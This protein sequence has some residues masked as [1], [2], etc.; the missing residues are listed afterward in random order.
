MRIFKTKII[1]AFIVL[2]S[3]SNINAQLTVDATTYTPTQLVQDILMGG[4]V[5]VSNVQFYGVMNYSGRY[6]LSYFTTAGTTTTQMGIS[7]GVFMTSGNVFEIPG[8]ANSG[9]ASRGYTSGT[10]GEVRNEA[11][12]E[13]LSGGTSS[14]NVAILE[15]DFVPTS[16]S[17]RFNYVFGSEEYDELYYNGIG[18]T[19]YQCSDYND[20]FGFLLSG[21]GISG[22]FSNSAENIALLA[23]G[24]NVCINSVNSGVVGSA[25]GAPNAS[26]C[27]AA[28]PDWINGTFSPEF[29]G[30]IAGVKFDGNTN[31]LTA[32]ANVTSGATYHIKLLVA[33]ISD[34]AYDSGVFLEQGSFISVDPSCTSPV[35][36]NPGSASACGSYTLPAQS[37]IGGTNLNDPRYFNN[38]QASGG[39]EITSLTL[40]SSQTVY[41]YDADGT[42]T[43]EESFTV[44]IHTPPTPAITGATSFC[45]GNSVTL[46]AGAGYSTYAWSNSTSNQSATVNSAG[47][48]VVTVTD[49]FGCTGT[50]S[51]IVT[52]NSNPTPVITGTLSFCDGS[53]TTINAGA[54]YSTYAWSNSTASQTTNITNGGTYTVTVTDSNG[55]SGTDS[56]TVT[57]FANP[58]A[59][60]TGALSFCSGGNTTL[61]A[62]AG[63]STYAWSNSTSS[64][65][66]T[67]NA[68]GSFTVTITDSNGC[69]DT[70]TV[71][72][73]ESASLT[74]VITGDLEFCAG[75]NTTLDA[76]SGYNDYDWSET[77]TNQTITVNAG[78]TFTVTVTDA[79]GCTGTT[80]ATVTENANPTPVI[81]GDLEFCEGEN[82]DLDAGTG[83]TD[84]L[85]TGGTSAQTLNVTTGGDYSVTVTDA[86]GC[87]GNA[88]VNI[89]VYTNPVADI[90]G[91]LSICSG[92]STTLD[93]GTGFTG[94]LWTGGS[95]SQTLNVTTGGTYQVTITGPGGCTATDAVTVTE[96]T[97]PVPDIIGT[98]EI[99]EGETTVLDAGSGY[100]E[101]NWT[102]GLTDQTVSTGTA[103]DFAVTVTDAN[104]CE[105]TDMV[106]VI[107][108]A[109]PIPAI[110]EPHGFC[111]GS[112]LTLNPGAGFASYLWSDS[113]TEST[114]T[115]SVP[116]DY[117]VTVANAEGC[118]GT[119]TVTISEFA[120]P[121]PTII[122]PE[123]FCESGGATLDAGAGYT[124]YDWSNGATTQTI[125]IITGGSFI[126][127]VTDANGCWGTDTLKVSVKQNPRPAI[128]GNLN[129]CF[130]S[131]TSLD[132]GTYIAYAWSNGGTD[133]LLTVSEAGNYSV[134][135][136]DINGCIGLDSVTVNELEDLLAVSDLQN[137]TCP[138][139]MDGSISITATGGLAPLIFDWS[140]GDSIAV[141]ENLAA[142]TY[143]LTVTDDNGCVKSFTYNIVPESDDCLNIPDFFSP[144][145]DLV[146]DTWEVENIGVY[147][148]VRIEIYNRWGQLMFEYSGSGMDYSYS[149]NQ[150]DGT[151]NGKE[152]PISSFVYIIDLKNGKEPLTGVVT[153]KK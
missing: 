49:A 44:T 55:C 37:T 104:G 147:D 67:I 134:T 69:S 121:V 77:S 71:S 129:M 103:G 86:N 126:V 43:D 96:N 4:G 124:V 117:S 90:T 41:I 9:Q 145:G 57:E 150:W 74:P 78:G 151:Y 135:V 27:L 10:T 3:F 94:Y 152:L 62:G 70:E 61:D 102:G 111:V 115:V 17:I 65:T 66:T 48:Y 68:S 46:N 8:A 120:N 33:D 144:N 107:V 113:S 84:Y 141:L 128:A 40:T 11:D 42:C 12:A 54:G 50:D 140:N 31:V 39:T 16:D 53:S 25:G 136:T 5:S 81:S 60:I 87:L 105:G 138:G 24:S 51:H 34:G 123:Y 101:Y 89:T 45:G 127:T 58:V 72:V 32:S 76:G 91:V 14:Y 131:E 148:E 73:T 36:T 146:N 142:G 35:I 82:T 22:I 85:W 106:T 79:S 59:A 21:P 7:S 112:S 47:T 64:Q 80:S 93:A 2:M 88:T 137:T 23:N 38:S 143:D 18:E 56:E 153:I 130:E 110:P 13:I 125:D 114:I 132:A 30:E 20:Q 92:A 109:N 95:T 29:R 6:Q 116:G 19:N 108:N 149:R 139:D 52:V 100:S 28:N 133:Q 99:C 119:L 122:G 1:L 97:N 26:N 83:Y 98:L 118:E 63:Y 15:F 75:G